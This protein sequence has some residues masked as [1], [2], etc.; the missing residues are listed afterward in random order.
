MGFYNFSSVKSLVCSLP[1]GVILPWETKN[2]A[3]L[4]C[5]R[6]MVFTLWRFFYVYL[7]EKQSGPKGV[8]RYREVY[9]I[10]DVHYKEVLLYPILLLCSLF[11]FQFFLI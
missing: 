10:W 6:Y 5:V 7:L 2:S 9:A 1:R 11:I 4:G 8:V 3:L